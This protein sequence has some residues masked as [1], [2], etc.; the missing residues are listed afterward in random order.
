MK[1][2]L[3]NGKESLQ[4]LYNRKAFAIRKQ[5]DAIFIEYVYAYNWSEEIKQRHPEFNDYEIRLVGYNSSGVSLKASL[6][7][8]L[9]NQFFFQTLCSFDKQYHLLNDLKPIFDGVKMPGEEIRQLVESA[10]YK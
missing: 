4:S 8:Y 2:K 7:E 5:V 6:H 3:F 1:S 9:N 10:I